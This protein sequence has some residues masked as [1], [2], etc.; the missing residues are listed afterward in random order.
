[1][2]RVDRRVIKSCAKLLKVFKSRQEGCHWD[3]ARAGVYNYVFRVVCLKR[4]A[5]ALRN[6][7]FFFFSREFRDI[8]VPIWLS[9]HVFGMERGVRG[10][11]RHIWLKDCYVKVKFAVNK[12]NF[13]A[14]SL[15]RS[16]SY[17]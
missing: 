16:I 17:K 6:H 7:L 1:M 9:D 15:D 13:F 11:R 3:S 12:T 4:P 2:T 10:A 14:N 8:V 5:R